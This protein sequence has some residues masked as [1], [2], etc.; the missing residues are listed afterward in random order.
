M[1]ANQVI[2]DALHRE[3]LK[4]GEFHFASD[5]ILLFDRA[6]KRVGTID[7]QE[8]NKAVWD[9]LNVAHPLVV[10]QDGGSR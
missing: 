7:W 3:L 2:A 6:G 5:G 4:M 1:N 8:G 10:P 9:A